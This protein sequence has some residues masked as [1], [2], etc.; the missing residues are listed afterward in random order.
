MHNLKNQIEETFIA[1]HSRHFVSVKIEIPIGIKFILFRVKDGHSKMLGHRDHASKVETTFRMGL[2]GGLHFLGSNESSIH[3]NK[4]H[5]DGHEH[6]KRNIDKDRLIGRIYGLRPYCSFEEGNIIDDRTSK[7]DDSDAQD[8]EDC[9]LLQFADILVGSFRSSFGFSGNDL[10]KELAIPIGNLV[11][12]Y[13]QGLTRMK[14]SRWNGA[15]CM[16]ECKL[17]DDRWTFGRIEHIEDANR[18]IQTSLL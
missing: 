16:S 14:N 9:Q 8:Y 11:K 18:P 17:T 10:H 15:L 4:I 7:H 6:L 13:N 12:K 3:I 5:F 2:K 1:V